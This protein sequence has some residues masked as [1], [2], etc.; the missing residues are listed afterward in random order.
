MEE[1]SLLHRQI[2]PSFVVNDIVSNQA[3]IENKFI[4]S[5]GA[6]MPTEKDTDKLS[7]YNGDKFSAKE[8]FEHYITDYTSCGVLSTTI[9][10]VKS[11]S[12]LSVTEDNY[13]F[14]GHSYIDFSVVSSKNQ[15]IKKAGLLRDIAVARN[16]TYKPE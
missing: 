10:E 5:S 1:E 13:P 7:V 6:F 12:L 2:H 8:S 16:W 3:F 14:D 9:Q 4:L 15:K 11:I